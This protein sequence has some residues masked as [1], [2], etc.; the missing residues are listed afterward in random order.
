MTQ[1]NESKIRD[2]IDNYKDTLYAIVGLMNLYRYDDETGNMRDDV[3]LFQG[4]KL[5][6]KTESFKNN[7]EG[8]E[9]GDDVTPDIGILLPNDTGVVGEVKASFPADQELWMDDFRQLMRYDQDLAG[10]PNTSGTVNTHDIILLLHIIR[11]VS[12]KRYY[13]DRKDGEI[14]F[15]RPFC[16]IEYS[17]SSQSKEYFFMRTQYGNVSDQNI[18]R[19]LSEGVQIPMFVFIDIYSTFKIYDAKPPLPYLLEIIWTHIVTLKASYDPKF[20][21][22][23]INQSILV[24][25]DISEI[26]HSL[27]N[28]FSFAPITSLKNAGNRVENRSPKYPKQSWIREACEQ[29]VKFG[30]A[31]WI[32]STK[33]KLKFKFVRRE[34]ILD[35]FIRICSAEIDT[36]KQMKLFGDTKEE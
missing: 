7:Y 8:L 4:W 18:D 12:V 5:L 1:H 29:L 33:E 27:A 16:I 23:R 9:K 30:D 35:Y 10:W 31:E 13:E 14:I 24:E 22:L 19:K 36:N 6:P 26:T 34:N 20:R 3:I 25:I 21:S 11:S 2:K 15:R 28:Q 32:G 17:R